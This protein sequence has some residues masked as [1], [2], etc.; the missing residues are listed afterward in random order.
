V[1]SEI[2][3]SGKVVDFIYRPVRKADTYVDSVKAGRRTDKNGNYNIRLG[4]TTK[5]LGVFSPRY[6]MLNMNYD[7]RK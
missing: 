4:A 1:D 2:D 5:L 7:G 6:G 3:V